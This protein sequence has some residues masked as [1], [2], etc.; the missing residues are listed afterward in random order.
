MSNHPTP[1]V[2]D[3]ATD[4]WKQTSKKYTEQWTQFRLTSLYADDLIT[5]LHDD[6]ISTR[7]ANN[8]TTTTIL[9]IGCG[10]GVFAQA[11]IRAFPDGIPG[12]TIISS[13]ISPAMI[14]QA[15]ESIEASTRHCTNYHTKFVCQVEDGSQLNG[16]ADHSI[17][18]VV[19]CYGVFLIPD[20]VA[21]LQ[22][23]RRVLTPGTGIFANAAWTQHDGI[24]TTFGGNLQHVFMQLS[25]MVKQMKQSTGDNTSSSTTDVEQQSGPPP[26][27]VQWFEP[28]TIEQNLTQQGY[29]KIQ[30]YRMFHS[31]IGRSFNSMFT[32]FMEHPMVDAT[33][34]PDAQ[35][36]TL[37]DAFFDWCQIPSDRVDK[38]EIIAAAAAEH[39]Q[40]QPFTLWTAA[41]LTISHVV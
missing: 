32:M 28:A 20:Q 10:P 25:G 30:T 24:D 15:R 8:T 12:H 5:F 34:L 33:S 23:I 35:V 4:Q 13:D 21:T 41:N 2:E 22:S 7:E 18:I 6:L 19:S 1:P 31:M 29:A 9:D 36:Q 14:E 37:K 40:Q 38:E 11:Y 26:S 16:I 27:F 3:S 17:D 39:V